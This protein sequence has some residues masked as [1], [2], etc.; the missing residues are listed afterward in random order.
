MPSIEI[1]MEEKV[2]EE[3]EDKSEDIL[4]NTD[5]DDEMDENIMAVTPGESRC[6]EFEASF[7][8]QLIL[9]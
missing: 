9:D 1:K 3:E 2:E 8:S 5:F 4:E 7:I 6:R